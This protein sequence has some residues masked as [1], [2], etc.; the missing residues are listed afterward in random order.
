M[1][2]FHSGAVGNLLKKK[3]LHPQFLLFHL[4]S[5]DSNVLLKHAKVITLNK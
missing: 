1:E 3:N 4:P 2:V 5:N